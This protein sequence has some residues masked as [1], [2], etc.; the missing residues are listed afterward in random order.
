MRSHVLPELPT[1]WN[2]PPELSH[3]LTDDC[4]RQHALAFVLH[5]HP[6]ASKNG[7]HPF[8]CLITHARASRASL[9]LTW[10]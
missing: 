3:A 6:C 4:M 1:Y 9:L 7:T 10:F 8:T 2:A 5:V